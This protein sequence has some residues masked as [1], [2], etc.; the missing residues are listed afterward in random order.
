M[1]L[2]INWRF[3]AKFSAVTLLI[4]IVV[5]FTHGWQASRQVGAF[6]RQ[7]DAAR[8]AKDRDEQATEREI[9]YLKRYLV[10]KPND[11]DVHERLARLIC[12]SAKTNQQIQEGYLV[13]QDVLRRDST[14]DDLRRFSADFA[15]NRLNDFPNAIADIDILLRKYPNEGELKAQKARCLALTQKY[16][17]AATFY[18]E[19]TQLRPDLVDAYPLWATLLRTELKNEKAADEAVAKMLDKNR[20]NFRAHLL[21]AGY[22]RTFWRLDQDAVR[23]ARPVIESQLNQKIE[24]KKQDNTKPIKVIKAIDIAIMEAKALAPDE[25][26]VIIAASD[27]LRFQSYELARSPDKKTREEAKGLFAASRNQLKTGLVK[28]PQSPALYLTLAAREAEQRQEKEPVAVIKE[29]LAAIPDSA[30]LMHALVDYQIHAGDVSGATDALTK[31]K[32]RG[33]LPT[34]VEYYESR[35]RMLKGEWSEATTGLDYVRNNVPNKPAF[36]REANLLLGRCYEQLGQLDRQLDA[37]T[38]AVPTDTTDT[39]W[40]PAMLAVAETENA[41]GKID[42][43]LQTY[44]KLKDR[45]PGVWLQISRLRMVKELQAPAN[46]KQGWRETEEALKNAEDILPKTM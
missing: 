37:F 41:L 45:A 18:G 25:L 14:R 39:L 22:W 12:Q 24:D 5:H 27:S 34:E 31:L 11:I 20:G 32:G 19:A 38:R 23:A 21:V 15:I 46:K 40:V 4:L 2:K 6:L 10:A 30:P 36:G 1:Q 7:A 26:D 9:T 33:L 42:A 16:E 29:G 44:T 28:H 8:D 35:I 17:A 13:V 3:L 43:S